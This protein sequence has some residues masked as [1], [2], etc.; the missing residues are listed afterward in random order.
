MIFQKQGTPT[1]V[2]VLIR[3]QK[4][5]PQRLKT[6]KLRVGGGSGIDL[7][8]TA[9]IQVLD[10]SKSITLRQSRHQE[11]SQSACSPQT[12]S[13]LTAGVQEPSANSANLL[14][15]E[16][17]KWKSWRIMFLLQ[18]GK[19]NFIWIMHFTSPFTFAA[20]RTNGFCL[21]S[22]SLLALRSWTVRHLQCQLASCVTCRR[23]SSKQKQ[24]CLKEEV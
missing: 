13:S 21:P 12:W 7:T 8:Q 19:A 4:N 16:R 5:K 22:T 15:S 1:H 20:K 10:S 23:E 24:S 17:P 14:Q 11:S 2:K 9:E 3:K 18:T 6:A